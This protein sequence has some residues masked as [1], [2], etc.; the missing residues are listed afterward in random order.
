MT[1]AQLS[2]G[3]NACCHNE[4][5]NNSDAV[6]YLSSKVGSQFAAAY[7]LTENG[8]VVDIAAGPCTI[9]W[10]RDMFLFSPFTFS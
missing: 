5:G 10:P 1:S 2:E 7:L 3:E 6:S 4:E 9:L 8:S